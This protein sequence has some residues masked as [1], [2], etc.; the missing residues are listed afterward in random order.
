MDVSKKVLHRNLHSENHLI[1]GHENVLSIARAP[2]PDST[3]KDNMTRRQKVKK[4]AYIFHRHLRHVTVLDRMYLCCIA[5][6]LPSVV[7]LWRSTLFFQTHCSIGSPSA[8]IPRDP[9]HR[10]RPELIPLLGQIKNHIMETG[11][12]IGTNILNTFETPYIL[13]LPDC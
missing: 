10:Q 7:H 1:P 6:Q 9:A 3:T 5:T 2:K 11:R 12:R 8:S 13:Y 4:E